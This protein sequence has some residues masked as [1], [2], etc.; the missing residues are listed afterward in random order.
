LNKTVDA[1]QR[2]LEALRRLASLGGLDS[3]SPALRELA[4]LRINNPDASLKEL[5]E[6]CNPPVGKSGINHRMRMLMGLIDGAN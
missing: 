5:G 4:T 2:Q 3:L 1:A 6:M